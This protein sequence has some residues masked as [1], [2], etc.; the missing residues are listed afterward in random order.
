MKALFSATKLQILKRLPL[1]PRNG[2]CRHHNSKI[3]PFISIKIQR[4]PKV[5]SGGRLRRALMYRGLVLKFGSL[6]HQLRVWPVPPLLL[7]AEQHTRTVKLSQ[8]RRSTSAISPLP[9]TIHPAASSFDASLHSSPPT[10]LTH[11]TTRH[12]V[13]LR[14]SSLRYGFQYWRQR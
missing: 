4:S 2:K 5:K 1:E 9:R 13:W 11:L 10:E 7:Q 12:G 6:C 14:S 3:M 8:L